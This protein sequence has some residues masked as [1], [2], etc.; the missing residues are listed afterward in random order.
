MSDWLSIT[1]GEAPLI[2]SIPHAGTQIPEAIEGRLE[3]S[4]LARVDTDWHMPQFYAFAA[5]LGA[6]CK[7]LSVS[8]VCPVPLDFGA[9]SVSP[10]S[11]ILYR[12][13][14]GR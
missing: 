12:S 9:S 6:T 14:G 10:G 5:G 1:R 4:W 7:V 13:Q 8:N 2:V 3:S 11:I